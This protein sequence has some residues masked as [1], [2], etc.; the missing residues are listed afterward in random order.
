MA[1]LIM[2]GIVLG[3]ILAIIAFFVAMLESWIGPMLGMGSY[4]VY[5]AWIIVGIILVHT[6]WLKRFD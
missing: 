4:T 2:K 1:G 5:I 6:G 3:I